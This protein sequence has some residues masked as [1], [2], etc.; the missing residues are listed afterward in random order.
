MVR[1][2]GTLPAYSTF[3][4]SDTFATGA[5]LHAS[6]T[7]TVTAL[8][9]GSAG[10]VVRSTGT[11]PAYSTFTIPDTYAQGDLLYGSATNVL[12]A[13]AK[14]ASATRYLANTGTS[15]NPAWAQVVLTDGVSGV[16]PV[17]NGGTNASSASIT[18]F[19][20]ITGYTAAGATGTTSTNLVFS[21]SPTLVTPALGTPA[22]GV[23]TNCTGLPVAGGGTGATSFT[24]DAILTGNTT[25]AIVAES[26]LTYDGTTLTLGGGQIA[27]P[28]TQAASAGSNTLDDYEEGTWTP[29]IGGSGGT[30]GQTYSVQV[31]RYVKI[32]KIVIA[33]AFPVLSAKGT[34]TDSVQIQGLPFT[35]ENTTN[36]V[37]VGVNRWANLATNWV[38][39]DVYVDVNTTIAWVEGA[40]A[41]AASA[42]T[43]LTTTDIGDTSR[44]LVTMIYR[45]AA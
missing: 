40:T 23:L 28:A 42:S 38:Y 14:N 22:S 18:A 34:I 36:L 39:I 16:L 9:V 19:N 7:D 20:N 13:L 45:A 1:S 29:V 17:A 8:A 35:A 3:T 2:T 25:S 32:G 12:T 5:L 31:G 44:F 10:Q 6:T 37:S 30:S 41:A 26:T 21:T 11:L 15:N 24:S 33:T 4:I 43:G 27:F